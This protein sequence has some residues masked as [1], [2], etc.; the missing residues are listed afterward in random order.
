MDNRPRHA[1]QR[2][3]RPLNQLLP[4]LHEYLNRHVVGDQI[5]FDQLSHKIEIGLTRRRESN[6][7]LL[8]TH[9]HEGVEHLA[10]A[11]RVH[12]IDQ[13]LVTVAKIDRAPKWGLGDPLVRPGPVQ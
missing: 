10:L 13:C 7:D 3:E 9:V 2:L 8:E 6:L 1:V 12:W 4:T 5:L 11:R